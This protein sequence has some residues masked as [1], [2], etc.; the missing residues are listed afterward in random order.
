MVNNYP[1]NSE[2]TWN[3]HKHVMMTVKMTPAAMVL[4]RGRGG[5]MILLGEKVKKI[6]Q[7][8]IVPFDGTILKRK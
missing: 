5:A 2:W 1:I 3:I 7:L 6:H 8:T 4:G